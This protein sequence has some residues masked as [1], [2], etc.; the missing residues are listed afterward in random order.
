M[1][2]VRIGE[3]LLSMGMVSQSQLDEALAP[4]TAGPQRAARRTAGAPGRRQPCRPAERPGPQDGL[5]AGRRRRLSGRSRRA[6][7]PALRRGR[8]AAGA[9][10]AAARR[11]ADR[12]A[13]RPGAPA[14]RHRRSRDAQPRSRPA[15]VLAQ[16]RKFEELLFNHYDKIGGRRRPRASSPKRHWKPSSAPRKPTSWWRRWNAKTAVRAGARKKSRSSS[17][18]TRWCG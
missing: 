13:G 12:R 1:P 3:A 7:P 16:S 15:P 9:A 5:P 10:A 6:A 14:Q 4:A 17:P 11:P 8:Q 18:T 2:M